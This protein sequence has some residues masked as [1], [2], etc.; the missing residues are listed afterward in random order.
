M[1][2]R[3]SS[4]TQ[5][6]AAM[7]EVGSEIMAIR[8]N[9]VVLDNTIGPAEIV[10]SDGKIVDILPKR[11]R[12]QTSGEKVLDVG[13]LVVMPGIIDPH[14]HIC[15]PGH[16]AGEGFTSV[17]K[18]AA[19]GGITTIVDMPLYGTPVL[20]PQLC[21]TLIPSYNLPKGSAIL[22]L[23]F[24][25]ALFLEISSMQNRSRINS[26]RLSWRVDPTEYSTFL[27]LHPDSLEVEATFTIAELCLLYKIPCHI[28]N[29]SSAQVLPIIKDARQKGAPITVETTHHYLNLSSESIPPGATYYKCSPPIRAKSNQE[30]LWAALQSR[31]IDMVVSAHTSGSLDLR[32]SNSGDF[33]KAKS[34]IASLQF[35][36]VD[37]SDSGSFLNENESSKNSQQANVFFFFFVLGN[38]TGLP[39]FW[40]SAKPRG[41]SLHDLVQLMCKNPAIL[42][43]LE[44]CK[45]SLSPGMDADLV[46]WNPETKFEVNRNIIHHKHKVQFSQAEVFQ[47]QSFLGANR[48][49]SKRG[50]LYLRSLMGS[51]FLV[52]QAAGW[53]R[54]RLPV[55]FTQCCRTMSFQY[56]VP[57]PAPLLQPLSVPER[58]LLGPGPSNC[59]PRVLSAGGRQLIGHVH[60]EMVQIMAEIKMGIQYAFQ[61][62]NPLTL[63]V[64]GTG[65]CAME[66]A[67]LN[68][69]EPGDKVLIAVSGFWGERATDIAKR[70]GAEVHQLVK[71]PG[72]YFTLE[73]IE[74]GLVQHTPLLFF[75]AHGESSTGV[76]QALEGIG[77]LCHRYN[78][79]LLV[80]AVAS[81]GG[82]PLFMDQQGIDILYSG[83]QKVLS[84][85]PGASPI[86]FSA[87]ARMKIHSRKTKPTSFYLDME[88]LCKY[89]GC[90]DNLI[91]YHHTAPINTFFC[92][93]EALAILV[94][95]GLESSWKLHKENSL[96]LCEGLQKL[97]LQLYVKE[98]HAR[99]P[100]VNT[101]LVPDEYDAME[102]TTYIM[103]N[104]KIEISGG[105]GPTAGKVLRIGLMG[106]NSTKFNVDQVLKALQDAL[107]HCLKNKL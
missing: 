76:V 45:G 32:E 102:I 103:K 61:T 28:V 16:P 1:T 35:G 8:S 71:G 7:V 93:R 95:K 26:A 94:E 101:V 41:F 34:G 78:C 66:A 42:S 17:T 107:Q 24:G 50:V 10:I 39:L 44:D 20:P 30:K 60:K 67:F 86:S 46:I 31:Q 3:K 15:E 33:L 105:L 9:K 29:L 49:R 87:R 57:P 98:P 36:L 62:Q 74:R 68:L 72:E 80:D 52:Q 59:P 2:S 85:P 92:L 21:L 43:R 65:H 27:D 84:A 19:A 83:A 69:V 56:L 63:A 54:V 89:W 25:V 90:D 64:S 58:L 97:G 40:T 99:L 12:V 37:L 22:T 23:R 11:N 48:E 14:V 4:A 106:Y 70:L 6:G 53:A 91:K 75:I 82:A 88:E 47:K 38:H 104:Y 79:L 51:V 96:Y 100:T 77:D 73:E 5:A 13:D 18:A 81:L 55:A